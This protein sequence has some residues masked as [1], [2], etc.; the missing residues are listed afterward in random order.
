MYETLMRIKTPPPPPPLRKRSQTHRLSGP[1]MIVEGSVRRKSP[2]D[3]LVHL[4]CHVDGEI[5]GPARDPG[6]PPRHPPR[7]SPRLEPAVVVGEPGGDG[8]EHPRLHLDRRLRNDDPAYGALR[9]E[10]HRH[11][12]RSVGRVHSHAL[13]RPGRPGSP[14]AP[15]EHA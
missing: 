10:T 11:S 8:L 5:P 12:D 2:G 9:R 14:A 15:A 4:A 1:Y 6:R 3:T 7:R 13:D